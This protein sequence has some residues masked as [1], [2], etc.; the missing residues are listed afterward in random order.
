M[1]KSII[2]VLSVVLVV[3]ITLTAAPLSGFVGLELPEWLNFSIESSA[4]TSGTCG[5]NLTWTFDESTGIL[6]ISGTGAMYDYSSSS[7]PWYSYKYKINNVVIDNGITTI[8]DYAFSGCSNL[9]SVT[10]GNSVTTIGNDA[11]YK[12]TGLT[13]VTI[14]D[15]VTTIGSYTFY[16]C[17]GLTSVTVPDSVTSI[18]KDAF[19][20]C[21][22]LTSVTIGGS[23]TTIGNNAFSFC[24]SLEKVYWNAKS[25]N[26]MTS[27]SNAFYYAGS[28]GNGIDLVFSGNVERIPAYLFYVSNTSCSP[29][30][31]SVTIGKN[32]KSIGSYAFYNCTKLASLYITDI[33]AW[34]EIS[35][36]NNSSNPIYFA[37][38]LYVSG[39]LTTNIMIPEGI[40]NI[41]KYAFYG[42]SSIVS[43]TIPDSVTTIGDY[44]FRLCSS[45][46]SVTIGDNV[47]I[48]GTQAFYQCG[49][50]TSITIPDS[51]EIIGNYAF[52]GCAGLASV[53]I[54]DGVTTI[55]DHA[56]DLCNSL[57]DVYYSGAEEEWNEISIGS[58]N[59]SLLNATIHFLKES[60]KCSY[61]SVV[62][63]PTCTEQGYT[64][65]T[66]ECGN[67]YVDD[68]VNSIGH[69]N[70][71]LD[72]YCDVCTSLCSCGD[73]LTWSFDE[74][75]GTLTIFGT[76]AMYDYGYS[77]VQ[78]WNNYKNV[79]KKV[80]ISN[81][82]TTI[83]HYAFEYYHNLTSVIIGNDVTTIRVGAFNGCRKLTSVTIPDSVTTLMARAFYYCDSLTKVEIGNSVTEIDDYAFAYCT[84]LTNI[85][86]PDCVKT[87]GEWL[88]YMCYDLTSVKIGNGVKSIKEGTFSNCY[89]LNNITIP[90]SVTGIADSVFFSC[91]NLTDV[92]YSGTRNDWN[93]ISINS[94]SNEYLSNATIHFL[95]EV[96]ECSF[97]AVV[98]PPTC[99]EQGYTTYTCECGESYVDNYVNATGHKDDD[100]NGYCDDCG[101]FMPATTGKCGENLT[102]TFD[103]S[104]GTLTISGTGE[105]DYFNTGV[106]R[107]WEDFVDDIQ[108]VII[109]DGV[110][111]IGGEA[112]NL[113]ENLVSVSISDTVTMIDMFAFQDCS[114]LTSIIIPNSVTCIGSDAFQN[115]TNLVNVIIGSGLGAIE[116]SP[117]CAFSG[118]VNLTNIEVSKDNKYFSS[119]NG[120]LF[121]KDKT[122]LV[123]FPIGISKVE[124]KI[125]DSVKAFE[126]GAF[127]GVSM[128]KIILPNGIT[129]I[130]FLTFCYCTNLTSVIIPNSV[131]EINNE[132]FSYCKNL[133][134]V[135][136]Y[137]TEEEWDTI[138]IGYNNEEL[139]NAT[140]HY[141]Y[142]P[143]FTGIDG[144]YFY[145]DGVMQKAYQL[146]EFEGNYY[147]INNGNMI[148][149][150]KRLYMSERFIEG[151]GLKVGYYE[152]DA[153]GKMILK[154]G[155]DG[156]YFYKDGVRQ[157]AY[158]LVEFEGNYYFINDS[159][160]LAKNK[161]IY[162]SERFLE[163]TNLKVGYYEFDADGKMILKNGPDGDYFYINGVRQNAYQ[164]VEFEGDYYFI[165][166]SNKLAKNKRIYLS[167]KFVEGTDIAVGYYEFDENGKMKRLNGPDGDYFYI[168]GV[169]QNAYQLVEFEGN[170]YFINDSHKLAKNKRLYM[171]Q[172]F[173]EGTDLKVGYYEFD[174]DGKMIIE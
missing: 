75:T 135:Y 84:T 94:S 89:D 160:K 49:N 156:D 154:N 105:M 18:G 112:F 130:P 71:N 52:Y 81:G 45:L 42:C 98:T 139:F 163:G 38:E 1:K 117:V 115:C 129:E 68:Y 20:N 34:C 113:C 144:D 69:I 55:G 128:T 150:N 57:T 77:N 145:K 60:H 137:G 122:V 164:L 51:V 85:V 125:P 12:C 93:K 7:I 97:N 22:S 158:Q 126:Q 39:S 155:P 27:S 59:E 88:F 174:A 31:T 58:S 36:G 141:D 124:Y 149:K 148:A 61:N 6:T 83:G 142:T 132:A 108:V 152:F 29:K 123:R 4:A 67:S 35:F 119:E 40:T 106:N 23:V 19:Y 151:T 16:K 173:V 118:C 110:T 41:G 131:T 44:A 103:E 167:A 138:S 76:G 37:D 111:T 13:S 107:P 73:N 157:N 50:L 47:D 32:V 72:A 86:I 92:Y 10:I 169:R 64:T 15:S 53:T 170:Y 62:T 100:Y 140:I 116:C 8:G 153:D 133:T 43:V 65:Y 28:A 70:N 87:L 54:S 162:L 161:R 9:T 101:E 17:T 120:I 46:T 78:P 56:F 90:T 114:S 11:F 134:D 165:N 33:A 3:V 74:Y 146:V 30:I 21:T 95:G 127:C 91:D 82:V 14:P 2:K 24:E 66:C 26:D 109:E 63:P 96:H 99:T 80:V 121:N 168:N 136:Y 171:S 102:W 25:V 147:F 159:H 48:I 143:P 172:R 104:T 5:D 79:I 166:D